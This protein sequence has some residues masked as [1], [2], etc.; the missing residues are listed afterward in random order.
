M[1]QFGLIS[2]SSVRKDLMAAC[3]KSV[4]VSQAVKLLVYAFCVVQIFFKRKD[5]SG[6]YVVC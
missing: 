5:G 3:T 4:S 1:A 6:L 2:R